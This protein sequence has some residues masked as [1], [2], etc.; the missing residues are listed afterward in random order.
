VISL[1]RRARRRLISNE[2][3]AQGAIAFIAALLGFILLLLL[4]TQILDWRWLIAIPLAAL[5]FGLYRVSKRAPS[6]YL[7]ARIL[8]HRLALADTLS[9]A[10][11]YS[12]GATRIRPD[13]EVRTCQQRQ[14]ESL[15]ARVD[16]RA[17]V[18]FLLPRAVY[19]VAVLSWWLPACS[20]CAT[21]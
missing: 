10:T 7:V 19:A 18:P 15:A 13:P 16:V 6:E 17:A 4:G 3:F 1:I 11:V 8:D 21:A 12:R 20:R 9:T 14:A 5:G 2:L